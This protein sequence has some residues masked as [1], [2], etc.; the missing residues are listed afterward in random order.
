MLEG[1][2]DGLGEGQGVG[3]GAVFGEVCVG[4]LEGADAVGVGGGVGGL[5]Q[6]D[7]VLG[8]EELEVVEGNSAHSV[9]HGRLDAAL[10]DAHV[11]DLGHVGGQGEV[12]VA[13][14]DDERDGR[15][16]RQDVVLKELE[17]LHRARVSFLS[18]STIW[19]QCLR[20]RMA[21]RVSCSPRR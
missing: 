14:H 17:D 2:G 12:G 6:G 20:M 5:D 21:S 4:A 1:E 13:A 8:H 15:D 18:S 16:E 3:Q 7:V 9:G 11:D 10:L 19:L